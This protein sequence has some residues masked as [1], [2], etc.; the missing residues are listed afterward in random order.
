MFSHVM[1]GTNDLEKSKAFYDA[2]LGTLGV[3]PG[4]VDRYRVF[5]RTPTGTF[6]VSQAIDGQPAD[7]P[8]ESIGFEDA[9]ATGPIGFSH[10]GSIAYWRESRDR[11]TSAIVA[12]DMATVGKWKASV[13]ARREH[14][15]MQ[16]CVTP[17]FSMSSLIIC[18]PSAL[19]RK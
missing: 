10:D 7:K 12:R 15:A 13:L 2:V 18:T 11:D 19:H 17:S 4:F 16:T 3:K 9:G 14:A 5:W 1:I 6:S 8:S